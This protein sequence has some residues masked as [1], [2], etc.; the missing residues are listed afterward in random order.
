MSHLLYG[1]FF[2]GSQVHECLLP[3]DFASIVLQTYY[4]FFVLYCL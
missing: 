4:M 2:L 1:P 3:G